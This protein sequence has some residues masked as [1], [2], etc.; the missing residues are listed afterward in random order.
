[1]VHSAVKEQSA[2]E[3]L[4][5]GLDLLMRAARKA[6]HSVD[7]RLEALAQR[8]LA[9]L[10]EF[11]SGSSALWHERSGVDPR[12]VEKLATDTGREIAAFVEHVALGVESTL[13]GSNKG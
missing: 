7:P 10:Q 6:T 4:A 12:Q 11:D 2:A 1:M 5:D 13:S 3:D 8:A 9:R